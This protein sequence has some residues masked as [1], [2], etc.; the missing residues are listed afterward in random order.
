MKKEKSNIHFGKVEG[1]VHVYQQVNNNKGEKEN[2]SNRFWKIILKYKI[3]ASIAT[4]ASL[5]TI[6]AYFDIN[7]KNIF[8]LNKNSNQTIDTTIL[9]SKTQ[10][11]DTNANKSQQKESIPTINQPSINIK[12]YP[13]KIRKDAKEQKNA[14]DNNKNNSGLIITYNQSGGQNIVNYQGGK[15]NQ[16]NIDNR[17]II[18]DSGYYGANL[19]KESLVKVLPNIPYSL[20][21]TI[22]TNT[23]V[24]IIITSKDEKPSRWVIKMGTSKN[25]RYKILSQSPQVQQFDLEDESGDIYLQFVENGSAEFAYYFNNSLVWKKN[26][27]W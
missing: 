24:R 5:V 20:Q 4:V 7:L 17:P 8:P 14:S 27:T 13:D 15:F 23:S 21:C 16:A 9:T 26:I 11:F 1:D 22:P 2:A 3:E 19:L 6:L 18:N 10:I 25:W 12:K